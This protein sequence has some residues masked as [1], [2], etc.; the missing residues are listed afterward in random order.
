VLVPQRDLSARRLADLL[1]G[2]TRDTLAE[3][4]VRARALAKPDAAAAVAA[5]C[6]AIAA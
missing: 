4:A 6:T 5:V 2:F 3:M 1:A